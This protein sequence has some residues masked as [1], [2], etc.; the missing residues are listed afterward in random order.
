MD[1]F[2][3]DT[4]GNTIQ[5]PK[6]NCRDPY[7]HLGPEDWVQKQIEYGEKEENISGRGL[8]P[9]IQQLNGNLI[10][11]EIGVCHG[12]TTKFLLQNVPNISKIYCIDHYP[13]YVEWDGTRLTEERQEETKRKCKERLQEYSSVEFVYQSS[14]DFVNN[15]PDDTL[16]FIFIDG[17]HSYESTIRDIEN[18]WPKMKKGGLFSGHDINLSSVEKAVRDFFIDQ[19]IEF[20][21]NNAWF[22]IK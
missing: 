22:L 1:N 6:S 3:I 5:Q 12:F 9:Y 21:E 16:D 8:L 15:I 19:K 18:Y 2:I 4:R 7:D 14:Q 11:C 17:E 10:G 20:V 13:S